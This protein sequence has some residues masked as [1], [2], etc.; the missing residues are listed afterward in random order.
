MQ[1]DVPAEEA[2][3]EGAATQVTEPRRPRMSIAEGKT[4]RQTAV[5]VTVAAA[6]AR[7]DDETV[8]P[9]AHLAEARPTAGLV[10]PTQMGM[11]MII[12]IDTRACARGNTLPTTWPTMRTRWR[13]SRMGATLARPNS[14]ISSRRSAN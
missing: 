3:L 10:E 14:S 11:T 12:P 1:G 2:L 5:A 6:V 13:L 9:A 8:L 7:E 4:T